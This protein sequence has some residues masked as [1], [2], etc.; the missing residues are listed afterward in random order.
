MIVYVHDNFSSVT[1]AL[2]INPIFF[3]IRMHW[4]RMDSK[5]LR[6]LS[7]SLRNTYWNCLWAWWIPIG[8]VLSLMLHPSIKKREKS[9]KF[10]ILKVQLFQTATFSHRGIFSHNMPP[11]KIIFENKFLFKIDISSFE[12]FFLH[13]AHAAPLKLTACWKLPLPK[14]QTTTCSDIIISNE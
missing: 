7:L 5:Y 13:Q 11:F 2:V 8:T 14:E 12:N 3:G 6:K 4:V 9:E 10:K 1:A